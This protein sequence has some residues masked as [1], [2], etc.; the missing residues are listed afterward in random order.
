MIDIYLID[1]DRQMDILNV[2][3]IM[4]DMKSR[5]LSTPSHKPSN[6]GQWKI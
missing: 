4:G 6:K 3:Q 5:V 1:H 2:Q